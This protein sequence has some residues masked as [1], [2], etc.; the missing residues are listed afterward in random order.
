MQTAVITGANTGIGFATAQRLAA[1][2]RTV[3]MAC[4]NLE[5]GAAAQQELRRANPDAEVD[6]LSLDLSSL[7]HI[8]KFADELA[9]RHPTVDVLVNNAGAAVARQ[10]FTEDGFELQFG[11]NYL[12]PFL[13]THL[14]LPQL[15]VAAAE[16]GDARIVHVS[17][18]AHNMGRIAPGTFRGR[19]VYNTMA[20][21]AQ[22]KLGN[23]MFSNALARR[24]PTGLTTHTMHPG[25]V[26]SDFYRQ[27]PG[28]L[29]RALLA[30]LIPP[31]R[32]AELIDELAFGDAYRTTSGDY[33]SV[34]RFAPVNPLSK[35]RDRQEQLYLTSCELAG[36]EPLEVLR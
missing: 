36:V 7:A 6:L 23:L 2:G 22:S 3:V 35:S 11:A 15:Q 28:P 33:V 21:Y 18:I 19:G 1:E 29:R 27:F 20:A 31:E 17:S 10:S 9:E 14:L 16:S 30:I 13:L 12:G 24:L 25:G 34:G 8:R 26:G 5:K 32:P 4:R